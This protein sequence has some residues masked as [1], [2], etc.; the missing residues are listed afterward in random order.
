MFHGHTN[1]EYVLYIESTKANAF[2]NFEEKLLDFVATS[3]KVSIF[4][5]FMIE[6]AVAADVR[7]KDINEIYA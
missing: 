2:D 4:S 1:Y 7:V 3:T 5:Q 6:L